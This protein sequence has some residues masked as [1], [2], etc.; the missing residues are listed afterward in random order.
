[1]FSVHYR[2]AVSAELLTILSVL[3][4]PTARLYANLGETVANIYTF[5]YPCEGG[6]GSKKQ[7]DSSKATRK[8]K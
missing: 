5:Y 3:V 6:N 8:K 2:R 1:M 4:E 7:K